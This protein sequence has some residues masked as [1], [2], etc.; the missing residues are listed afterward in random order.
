MSISLA[1]RDSTLQLRLKDFLAECYRHQPDIKL[2]SDPDQLSAKSTSLDGS[3]RH[4][5]AWIKVPNKST[6]AAIL[7]SANEHDIP[8]FTISTGRNWGFGSHLPVRN[9]C[10]L[11][12][13]GE[14]TEIS[15]YDAVHG[16][17]E[18][19]P[20]VT[21]RQLSQYLKDKQS[22]FFVDVTGSSQETSII[23]NALERGVSY[24]A[25]RTQ[26]VAYIEV[27]L[28]TGET[29][30]TGFGEYAQSQVKALY[31]HGVGPSLDQLFFQSNLGIVTK[32]AYQLSPRPDRQYMITIPFSNSQLSE[33][34]E[35]VRYLRQQKVFSS[36]WHIASR[37]RALENINA[38]VHGALQAQSMGDK[39]TQTLNQICKLL[40]MNDWILTG[41][42]SGT[43]DVASAKKKEILRAFKGL[44]PA[45]IIRKEHLGIA[46]KI[47]SLL[48]FKAL[49]IALESLSS[50]QGLNFGEPT[51][52][53]LR[54]LFPN[55]ECSDLSQVDNLSRR[56]AY[57]TPLAPLSG[58]GAEEIIQ[59]LN[60]HF[61]A[62]KC[63]VT[64]N[65][66]SDHILEG[67]ISLP[68]DEAKH[69]ALQQDYI[70][71]GLNPYRFGISQMGLAENPSPTYRKNLHAIK[72]ILDPNEI[73]SPGRYM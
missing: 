59:V 34:I 24:Q 70:R 46:P 28:A 56:F 1:S 57:C 5:L 47:L 40:Q 32:M 10:V 52:D 29:I 65:V 66:I 68:A 49:A 4:L 26:N 7:K 69:T 41:E 23:G 3:S 9:N 53:T 50:L 71:R 54:S 48:G 72:K 11:I 15:N 42:V 51:N 27:L 73:L 64:L 38:V 63:A 39:R 6:L 62:E 12:D 58:T 61:P 19:E 16:T 33:V 31:Q 14:W 36:V 37:E 21:Q 43:K 2:I 44:A 35:K 20:G 60:K 67:V 8:L 17:V 55:S 18:I 45:R 25:L 13:L 30:R 22:S